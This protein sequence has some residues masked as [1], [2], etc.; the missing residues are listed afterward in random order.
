MERTWECCAEEVPPPLA[1]FI[2]FIYI[3]LFSHPE[4]KE[5]DVLSI[6][7]S[8]G[9]CYVSPICFQTGNGT[10]KALLL[11]SLNEILH[12]GDGGISRKIPPSS[13]QIRAQKYAVETS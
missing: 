1:P 7:V 6:W 3:V 13:E 5:M 8:G 11:Y 12:T 2:D 4:R 9:S 10:A